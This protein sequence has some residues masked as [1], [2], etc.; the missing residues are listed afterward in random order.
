MTSSSGEQGAGLWLE[1][2]CSTTKKQILSW[3]D[4]SLA[5]QGQLQLVLAL[6]NVLALVLLHQ[7]PADHLAHS[8]S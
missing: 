6:R 3:T 5:T 4:I 8:C 7:S 2:G 1:G